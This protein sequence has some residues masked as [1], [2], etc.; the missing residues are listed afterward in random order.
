MLAVLL[1]L[2]AT[3]AAAAPSADSG[4]AATTSAPRISVIPLPADL[5]PAAPRPRAVTYSDAYYLR[6]KIHKVA[7]YA[8]IPLFVGEYFIGEKLY[9]DGP[10]GDQSLKGV[11][12]LVATGIGGLFVVNTVTGVWNLWES[13]HDRN[14]RTRRWLHAGMMIAADAGFVAT[15][16]SAPG[17]RSFENGTNTGATHQTLAI[18]SMSVALSSYLMMLIW[19]N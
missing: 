12:Q 2:S 15:G 10:T 18:A 4:V 1:Q 11:H 17:H 19:K 5:A 14:D 9:H 6:L 7:S 3:L 8:T 16:A 13:R